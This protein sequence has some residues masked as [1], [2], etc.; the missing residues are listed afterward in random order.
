MGIDDIST[1][2][3]EWYITKAS[4]I[5]R[6]QQLNASRINEDISRTIDGYNS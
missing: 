2:Y 3:A 6:A 1:L 4:D 5:D